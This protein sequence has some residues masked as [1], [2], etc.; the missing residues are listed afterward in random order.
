VKSNRP[1]MTRAYSPFWFNGRMKSL[2]A[3][4]QGLHTPSVSDQLVLGFQRLV[5]RIAERV[6]DQRMVTS[7]P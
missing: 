3:L 7:Y 1:A 2:N 5:A 4:W 6:T